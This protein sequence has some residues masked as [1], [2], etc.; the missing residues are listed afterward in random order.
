MFNRI[1]NLVIN[2]LQYIPNLL[3]DRRCD[4][5]VLVLM[6]RSLEVVGLL[7]VHL[8]IVALQTVAENKTEADGGESH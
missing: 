1:P 7:V 4:S 8:S 6:R 2:S 3:L 5:T